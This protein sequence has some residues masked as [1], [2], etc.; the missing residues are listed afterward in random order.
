[1]IRTDIQLTASNPQVDQIKSGL[2]LLKA[3]YAEL[4]PVRD[5]LLELID[6]TDYEAISTH[7]GALDGGVTPA[8]SVAHDAFGKVIYNLINGAVADMDGGDLRSFISRFLE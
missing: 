6:G 8:D 1:M 3:A 2:R 4:A 5:N 7:L